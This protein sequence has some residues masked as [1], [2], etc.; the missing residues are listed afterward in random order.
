MPSVQVNIAEC[1]VEDLDDKGMPRGNASAIPPNPADKSQLMIR[2]RHKVRAGAVWN[3]GRQAACGL[4]Q[5]AGSWLYDLAVD[6]LRGVQYLDHSSGRAERCA[7]LQD[8]SAAVIVVHGAHA[9][10]VMLA[11]S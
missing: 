5:V 7:H 3:L 1:A 11:C 2:I 9:S 6:R 4:R 8:M 10:W